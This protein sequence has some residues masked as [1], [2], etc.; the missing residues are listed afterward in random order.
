MRSQR[1]ISKSHRLYLLYQTI[2]LLTGFI[3][4]P[5]GHWKSS[6]NSFM[7][8]MG[9]RTLWEEKRKINDECY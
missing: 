7:F 9:P 8:D 4:D 3:F 6:E 1:E 2:H 5:C